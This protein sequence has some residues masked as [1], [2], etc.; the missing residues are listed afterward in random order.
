MRGVKRYIRLMSEDEGCK[1]SSD[2]LR[3]HFRW[4]AEPKTPEADRESKE[5]SLIVADTVRAGRRRRQVA[6]SRGSRRSM[7]LGVV[8]RKYVHLLARP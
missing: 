5:V 6:S 8:R 3:G 7:M 2:L 1:G 4:L